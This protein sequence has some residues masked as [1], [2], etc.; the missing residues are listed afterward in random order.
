MA[1]TAALVAAAAMVENRVSDAA[2]VVFTVEMQIPTTRVQ[3]CIARMCALCAD[4][5]GAIASPPL[6][7]PPAPNSESRAAAGPYRRRRCTFPNV[8]IFARG[9]VRVFVAVGFAYARTFLS[10][11]FLRGMRRCTH[12]CRCRRGRHGFSRQYA[13]A[14]RRSGG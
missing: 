14:F 3:T 13:N 1:V 6:H 9:I 4:D 7:T 11:F 10:P 8:I 2:R 12:R 5:G